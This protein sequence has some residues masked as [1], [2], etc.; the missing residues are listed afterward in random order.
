MVPL[1]FLQCLGEARTAVIPSDCEHVGVVLHDTI[2]EAHEAEDEARR[3][4]I[5]V[6][7]AKRDEPPLVNRGE[8]ELW[9]DDVVSPPDRFL[10]GDRGGTPGDAPD[11]FDPAPREAAL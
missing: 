2:S 11:H 4:L 7:V 3:P 10:D 8:H 5:A 9:R 6:D 1:R